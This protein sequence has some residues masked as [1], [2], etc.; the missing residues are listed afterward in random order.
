MSFDLCFSY[1]KDV[2]DDVFDTMID[3]YNVGTPLTRGERIRINLSKQT[4]RCAF[5]LTLTK[6]IPCVENELLVEGR[7]TD[8]L[9][10]IFY[11]AC[12][13]TNRRTAGDAE[14]E[15]QIQLNRYTPKKVADLQPWLYA[16]DPFDPNERKALEVRSVLG[17]L[18][19]VLEEPAER[20]FGKSLKEIGEVSNTGDTWRA[21]RDGMFGAVMADLHDQVPL[22]PANF[23]FAL[24][25]SKQMLT[26]SSVSVKFNYLQQQRYKEVSTVGNGSRAFTKSSALVEQLKNGGGTGKGRRMFSP[27][28]VIKYE[29]G[30]IEQDHHVAVKM[31]DGRVAFFQLYERLADIPNKT[32]E[33]LRLAA[34]KDRSLD[35]ALQAKYNELVAAS[36]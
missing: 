25:A 5:V 17:K 32:R 20:F 3:R 36:S 15:G 35:P 2:S 7:G 13:P 23:Q 22:T 6:E 12:G 34:K 26:D 21:F 11:H 10:Q 1:C 16:S 33:A 24:H 28:D 18:S 19:A 9:C 30:D 8:L 4:P 14:F 31:P 29:C 27:S